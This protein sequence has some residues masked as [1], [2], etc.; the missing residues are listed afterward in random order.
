MLCRMKTGSLITLTGL[1]REL[2]GDRK[3]TLVITRCLWGLFEPLMRMGMTVLM[4][5]LIWVVG[6]LQG[7]GEGCTWS[8]RR[9]PS[10]RHVQWSL[11]SDV[12]G[13]WSGVRVA[14]RNTKQ[15]RQGWP[16][17]CLA[18]WSG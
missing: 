3:A 17:I 4:L 16:G 2:E 6:V 5:L 12:A 1:A 7:K 8:L 18:S 15:G 11:M 9:S 13:L 10:P 14:C